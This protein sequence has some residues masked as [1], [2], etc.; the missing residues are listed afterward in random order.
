MLLHMCR[1]DDT[2]CMQ[3][4]VQRAY[5]TLH[6]GTRP[7]GESRWQTWARHTREGEFDVS[8]LV[9]SR[10]LG[11]AGNIPAR[12]RRRR[13][14]RR[15]PHSSLGAVSF[16]TLKRDHGSS[17]TSPVRLD[18]K[19]G[20]HTHAGEQALQFHRAPHRHRPVPICPERHSGFR[21]ALGSRNPCRHRHASPAETSASLCA[22]VLSRKTK[23]NVTSSLPCTRART[24][25]NL[26]SKL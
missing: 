16:G 12:R 22:S 7:M 20:P 13:R 3:T 1:E 6:T 10:R 4:R 25:H 26:S 9:S 23:A 5:R 15:A 24:H 2:A 17:M 18:A 8:F 11:A 21:R 19:R 14:R